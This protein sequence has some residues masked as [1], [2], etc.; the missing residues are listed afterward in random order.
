MA[1]PYER[2]GP[3]KGEGG[4]GCAQGDPLDRPISSWYREFKPEG[5]FNL[6]PNRKVLAALSLEDA[7]AHGFERHA[8]GYCNCV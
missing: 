2:I 4:V 1:L 7:A 5:S 3:Q 8:F 6:A